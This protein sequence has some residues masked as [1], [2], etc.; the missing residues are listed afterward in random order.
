MFAS[1]SHELY[2]SDQPSHLQ[3]YSVLFSTCRDLRMLYR[4]SCIIDVRLAV[5]VAHGTPAALE[6]Q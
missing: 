6:V 1:G 2:S 5:F 3:R 4:R